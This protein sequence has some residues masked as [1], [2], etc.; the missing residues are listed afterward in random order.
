[1][2]LTADVFIWLDGT[3]RYVEVF[4]DFNLEISTPIKR[5]YIAPRYDLS[6]HICLYIYILYIYSNFPNLDC[7]SLDCFSQLFKIFNLTE[8]L[9]N[10]KL[11]F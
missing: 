8:N 7:L 11:D 9:Y 6:K 2:I 5:G 1:M 10:V 4:I 3:S